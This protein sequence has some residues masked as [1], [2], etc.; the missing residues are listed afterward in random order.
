MTDTPDAT[1][2]PPSLR[3]LKG[4]VI[5]LMITMILGVIAVVATLV[6][7]M[8]DGTAPVLPNSLTLPEGETATAVTMGQG[9][10]AVVTASQNI[11]IFDRDGKLLQTVP[12]R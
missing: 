10:F 2:L 9:W 7:R 6:T 3:F 12:L 11:L 5:T 4:L 8:P 1:E